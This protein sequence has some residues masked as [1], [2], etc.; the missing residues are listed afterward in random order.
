MSTTPAITYVVAVKGGL[1]N[2]LRTVLGFV[3]VA[4]A[5]TPASSVVV[6]WLAGPACNGAF[7]DVFSPLPPVQFVTQEER[8]AIVKAA[9]VDQQPHHQ[10]HARVS[11]AP[12]TAA[13]APGNVGGTIRSTVIPFTGELDI[14]TIKRRFDPTAPKKKQSHHGRNT[15]ACGGCEQ[16]GI[17]CTACTSLLPLY[18][19]VKPAAALQLQ[20]DTFAANHR[21]DQCIGLHVRRTDHVKLAA[22]NNASTPDQFF[23][24]VIAARC[25]FSNRN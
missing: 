11:A 18:A 25:A 3:N 6:G 10:L 1:A 20:I 15:K 9:M 4:A 23:L 2:R 17:S 16:C 14:E 8:M 5:T 22:I 21:L 13:E 12:S 7:S 24:D 19:A